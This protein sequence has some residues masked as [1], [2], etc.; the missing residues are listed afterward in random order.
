MVVASISAKIQ[1]IDINMK[2]ETINYK[3]AILAGKKTKHRI[4]KKTIKYSSDKLKQQLI[5]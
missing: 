5:N 1:S 2:D 4:L 3:V